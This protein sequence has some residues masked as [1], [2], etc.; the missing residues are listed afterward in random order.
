MSD[1]HDL[2]FKK[3]MEHKV[4]FKAFFKSYLPE[5]VC[6]SI[7]WDSAKIFKISNEHIRE[8]RLSKAVFNLIK[9]TGDI[10]YLVE[11][12]NTSK[13]VL[14][15]LH[16]EH[17]ATP[18]RYIP[19]R[20]ALYILGVLYEFVR[21]NPKEQLPEVYSVIYY[22]GVAAYP[23]PKNIWGMFSQDYVAKQYLFDPNFIDLRKVDDQTLLGHQ[24][25]G[26]AEYAFKHIFEKEIRPYIKP[27]IASLQKM[28]ST[29]KVHVVKYLLAVSESKDSEATLKEL[30][31][32][33]GE[34]DIMGSIAKYLEEKGYQKGLTYGEYKGKAEGKL[35]GKQ[36]STLEIARN[37]L[38]EGLSID[39]IK[40]ITGIKD[41]HLI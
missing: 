20:T 10:A 21:I 33:L 37:M 16:T 4:F 25:I 27:M 6:I 39:F 30:D 14:I 24:E 13:K 12:K 7:N 15:Y 11:K 41:S 32:A 1:I 8:A 9:A 5:E 26:A 35:E 31:E 17:Q 19:L 28:D 38:K 29:I 23:Y 2:T 22:H 3:L 36:E 18:D 40:K 34:E